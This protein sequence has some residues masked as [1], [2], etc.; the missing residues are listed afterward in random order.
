MN[1]FLQRRTLS[2]W[3]MGVALLLGLSMP[4]AYAFEEMADAFIK[5]I[6][7]DILDGIKADKPFAVVKLTKSSYWLTSV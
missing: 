3:T 1:R 2:V 6:S 4:P 5:R 7:V